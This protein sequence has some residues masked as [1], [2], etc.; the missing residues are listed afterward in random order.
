MLQ[1]KDLLSIQEVRTKVEK[2]HQAWL[3]YRV[4]S[5]EQVDRVVEGMAAAARANARRMA[6]LAVEETGYGNVQDKYIKNLLTCDWLPRRMRGMKTVGVLRE[7]PDE[8]IVEMGVPLGVIAAILPTTNPTSTAIYKILVSLKAGNSVVLSPHPRAHQSTCATAGVLYRAAVEAGAPED[9]IQCVDAATLEGTNALMRH[10]KVSAIL[11]TGGSGMVKA[12][13]SSGKPAFGVGPGNVPVLVDTSAD[14]EDAIAKI[15][16]G[17]SFDYGTVCSSEQALVAEISLRDRILG[18][19]ANH[20]AHICNDAQKEALGKLLVTPNWTINPQC[21][22]QAPGKLARMAGFDVPAETSILCAEVAGV[23]KQHPLSMEKL[24][25]VLALYFVADFA[26]AME[27]CHALLRFGGLGHTAVIYS[28]NDA[29]TREYGLR[30]PAMRVLVN[31]PAPQGSTGITTNVFPSMTL[32]CGAMAGNITSDNVG[33]QHL[34]NIKRLAYVVRKPEEAFEMPL[35]VKAAPKTSAMAAGT[36]GAPVER[37]QVVAA[38]ERYLAS[39]GVAGP[40]APAAETPVTPAAVIAKVTA[41]VVDRV[42]AQR[43]GCESAGCES[44]SGCTLASPAAAPAE[45]APS[46][47]PPPAPKAVEFVCEADV[48]AAMAENKKIFIGPKTIVTPSARDLGGPSDILVL[49][50]G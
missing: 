25:P 14:L 5:Q 35:D 15:I 20:R 19:L 29:R 10:E 41:D 17:K 26:A 32:G 39:R 30:M 8:K 49:V 34:M 18:L 6:E 31:T 36:A 40:S 7:L 28:K 50:R 23:G 33:P 13:Y 22:G 9:V 46:P 27:T 11:A 1:D 38:V 2:A 45:E 47:P 21:V 43:A 37:A 24:S 4:F 42:L 3:K 48:R 12:A 44:K 16:A